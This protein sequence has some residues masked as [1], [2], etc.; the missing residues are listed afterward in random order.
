LASIRPCLPA[1][2]AGCEAVLLYTNPS[3]DIPLEVSRLTGGKGCRVVFDGVGASTFD[4]SLN[5]L[6][7]L[8]WLLSFGNA[9]GKV[10][11]VDLLK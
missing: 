3:Q 8:G 10:P 1:R 11:P 2:A 6:G 5:C 7:Y 9:S 4:L